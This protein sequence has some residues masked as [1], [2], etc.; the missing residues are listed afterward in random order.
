MLSTL[1]TAP[2]CGHFILICSVDPAH[3]NDKNAKIDSVT[4]KRIHFRIMIDLL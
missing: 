3:P 1:N 4:N 2:H